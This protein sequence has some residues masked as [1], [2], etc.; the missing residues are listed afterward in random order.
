MDLW[1]QSPACLRGANIWLKKIDKEWDG[2]AFGKEVVGPPYTLENLK[3]LASLGANWVNVSGPGIFT[4][5]PPYQLDTAILDYW[6]NLLDRIQAAGLKAVVSF[7]TG[8]GRNEASFDAQEKKR[9]L[10]TIW[11]DEKAQDAWISMWKKAAEAFKNHPAVIGFELMVEP[12]GNAETWNRLFPK[13][14]STIR[15]KDSMTPILVS[16]IDYANPESLEKLLEVP[17]K[18]IVYSIHSYTPYPYT[19]DEMKKA[20]YNSQT[21]KDHL[22]IAKVVSD[23]RKIPVALTE[24]GVKR[25]QPGGSAYLKDM[26]TIAESFQWPHAVWLWESSHP[27]IQYDEFNFRRGPEKKNKKDLLKNPLI[28]SLKK[29]WD[30]NKIS[31]K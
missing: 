27:G 28:Q 10:S 8:P 11:N 12:N 20:A 3:S 23:K 2:D 18:N 15:E 25:Y 19:H 7:R 21:I 17:D 13:L 9:S 6:K 5:T 31:F 24:Y 14:I 30:K 16:P 4:E 22:K 29:Q 1:R 26:L